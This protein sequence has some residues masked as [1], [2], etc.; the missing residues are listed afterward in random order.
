MLRELGVKPLKTLPAELVEAALEAP[1]LS[2][3]PEDES[4]KVQGGV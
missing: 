4:E 3:T 1:A 2:A